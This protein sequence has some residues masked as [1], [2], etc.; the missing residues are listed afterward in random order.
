MIA[1]LAVV[2]LGLTDACSSRGDRVI[3]L[4]L[5][6]LVV[7]TLREVSGQPGPARRACPVPGSAGDVPVVLASLAACSLALSPGPRRGLAIV[8]WRR[9]CLMI[10]GLSAGFGFRSIVQLAN[11]AAPTGDLAFRLLG[12]L[13][14]TV[15]VA[16]TRVRGPVGRRVAGL[17][18]AGLLPGLAAAPGRALFSGGSGGDLC[19]SACSSPCWCGRWRS[20]PGGDGS[21]RHRA[22]GN[23]RTVPAPQTHAQGACAASTHRSQ[24]ESRNRPFR[25]QA[26]RAYDRRTQAGL[27]SSR[28]ARPSSAR[29]PGRA[30]L[31]IRPCRPRHHRGRFEGLADNG[32]QV[33]A[34]QLA[35][36]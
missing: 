26:G 21:G 3:S 14:I 18:A 8:G 11:P 27:R 1:W 2:V 7:L 29:R 4:T 13:A 32:G 19:S 15:A 36:R 28:T 10:A 16:V 5:A 6:W 22:R 24:R 34:G 17:V 31:A 23:A 9:A 25:L 20:Y 30:Q 33:G 12:V 35:L